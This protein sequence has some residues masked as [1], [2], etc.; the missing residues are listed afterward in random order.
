MAR[1]EVAMLVDERQCLGHRTRNPV[2][3]ALFEAFQKLF[4]SLGTEA[5]D[6]RIL[7]ATSTTSQ[8][9]ASGF[10]AS[11]LASGLGVPSF[12]V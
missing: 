6:A 7:A 3:E 10:F 11:R 4:S 5:W 9:S 1:L 2:S 12:G 8:L